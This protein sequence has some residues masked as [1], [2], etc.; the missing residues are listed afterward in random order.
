MLEFPSQA[1]YADPAVYPDSDTFD[2]FRH[3][4]LRHGGSAVDH[5]RNQFVTTNE[6]N[7]GW[8]YGRHAC[9][10]RFF[11]ANEIKMILVRLVLGYDIKMPDGGKER[12]KQFEMGKMS[13][14]DP[15]KT[16][17]FKKVKGT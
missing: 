17:M 6:V 16:L 8:G 10:G 14:P 13:A 11:A 12:Y 15:G 1:V 2:G 7:L 3:Y 4:K 9:P 5:A